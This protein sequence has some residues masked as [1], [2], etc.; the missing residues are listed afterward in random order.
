V[1]R[2]PEPPEAPKVS[3]ILAA[4]DRMMAAPAPQKAEPL[5]NLHAGAA[6]VAGP[7]AAD[8]SPVLGPKGLSVERPTA[9][10]DALDAAADLFRVIFKGDIIP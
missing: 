4:I 7:P 8:P 3:P 2:R 10:K 5:R 1:V 6:S 9:T